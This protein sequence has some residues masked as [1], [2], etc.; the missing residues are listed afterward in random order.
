MFVSGPL[1]AT[2]LGPSTVSPEPL[3]SAKTGETGSSLGAPPGGAS[4]LLVLKPPEMRPNHRSPVLVASPGSA[5]R[6]R[7]GMA[8]QRDVTGTRMG[9]VSM[10]K[11]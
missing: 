9:G 11:F 4:L 10:C 8:S 6:Q 5:L 1:K 7:D 3:L 2:G